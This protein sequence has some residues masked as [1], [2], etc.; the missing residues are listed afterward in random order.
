MRIKNPENVQPAPLDAAIAD[1]TAALTA[2][3]EE[4]AQL[5]KEW[6]ELADARALVEVASR[7]AQEE[8][9]ALSALRDEVSGLIDELEVRESENIAKVSELVENLKTK[10]AARLLA[11]RDADFIVEVLDALDARLAAE[12]LGKMDG[13]Q[14]EDVMAIIATRGRPGQDRRP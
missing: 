4:R 7:R 9:A 8:I 1:T 6:R 5:E 10:D 3:R 14:A 11:T 12:I 2:I 13:V